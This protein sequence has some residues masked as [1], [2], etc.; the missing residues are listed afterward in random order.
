[1]LLIYCLSYMVCCHSADSILI[2]G[3]LGEMFE[4]MAIWPLLSATIEV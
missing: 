4:M 3:H 2:L 1:M